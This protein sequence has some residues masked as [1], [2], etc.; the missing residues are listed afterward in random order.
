MIA[1]VTM[2]RAICDGCKK[3]SFDIEGSEYDAFED[4]QSVLDEVEAYDWV[5]TGGRRMTADLP[6]FCQACA[7]NQDDEPS[8][9]KAVHTLTI[10]GASDDCLELEG[11]INEEYTAYRKATLV[12]R[13][14]TGAQLAI[15]AE[16][17]GATPIPGEGWA[18]SILHS[19]PQWT[20]PVRLS[21]RPDRPDDPAIVL[22]V[23]VG[24]TVREAQTN[25]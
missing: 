24:T 6:M 10:Y 12:L 23:P 7:P 19:D 2:Y 17:D 20:W 21:E 25:A 18:L 3:S 14:P 22:E 1:E 16:F 11:Y 8:E 4:V 15:T 9:E 5:T 13:A